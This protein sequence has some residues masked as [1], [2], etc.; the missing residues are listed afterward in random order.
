MSIEERLANHH[1]HIKK[2]YEKIEKLQAKVKKLEQQGSYYPT[3]EEIPNIK[4]G[5]TD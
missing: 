1:A 3:Q 5:G 2:L 4:I